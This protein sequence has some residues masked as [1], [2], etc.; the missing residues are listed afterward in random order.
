MVN[1]ID[2][3]RAQATRPPMGWNSWDCFGGSVTEAEVIANAE[4]LAEHLLHVGWDTVVVDIQWYEPEPGLSDYERTSRAVLD[5]WGRQLPAPNRFPSATDGTFRSLADRI[6]GL[7]LRFGVHLMR[8]V[9]RAAADLDLPI[10]GSS[11]TCGQIADRASVCS[12]NPDSYGVDMSVEGAQEYYDSVIAQLASW[13]VD[14]I[15]LDDV[16]YPPI[17]ADEIRA[18]S[19]AIDAT[20]RPIVLSLSP[21][22]RL[23]TEHLETLRDSAQLWRIS[24]DLWDDWA[25]L[26]EQF[27]RLA[28][29]APLQRAGAW[30]DADMLPLGRIGIRSH[31][32]VDR[33]SFLTSAEQRTMLTLWCIGRSP[34]MFGGHLP[35]TAPETLALLQNRGA[36]ALLD[37]ETS[38]EIIR[39]GDLVV[40]AA[41]HGTTRW[42]AVFWLGEESTTLRVHLADLGCSGAGRVT[43][44]WNGHQQTV[45]DGAIPLGLE[46]H[47]VMLLRIDA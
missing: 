36:L 5:G 18:I 21:G 22:K 29:W 47:G 44:V 9:P 16:L 35:D 28:R 40:W 4:Y 41:E 2:A 46:P 13:G 24:D 23:S 30:A 38:R 27:Q 3:R 17:E 6:H 10:L 26:R 20:G 32:G 43:E 8:G 11:A 1:A 14:F 31:V 7:G 15:K 37:A 33:Q 12:W 19:R 39:D 42:R 25:G 34:L 45:T